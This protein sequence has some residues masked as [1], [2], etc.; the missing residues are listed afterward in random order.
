MGPVQLQNHPLRSEDLQNRMVQHGGSAGAEGP[1]W[2]LREAAE[3]RVKKH[4][5]VKKTGRRAGGD[6]VPEHGRTAAGSPER[7][8]L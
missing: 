8:D 6:G 7:E 3:R 4:K 1:T 5:D 2:R